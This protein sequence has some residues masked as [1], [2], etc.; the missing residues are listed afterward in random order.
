[1]TKDALREELSRSIPSTTPGFEKM[2]ED[3]W[4]KE[5]VYY[6][7]GWYGSVALFSLTSVSMGLVYY[8]YYSTILIRY[9]T[10][11]S[12]ATPLKFYV[13]LVLASM[14][15]SLIAAVIAL[16]SYRFYGLNKLVLPSNILGGLGRYSY[17]RSL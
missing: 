14:T 3:M 10:K 2:L 5:V 17:W 13:D 1:V 8:V 7:S 9:L 6:T 12:K 4:S 11:Y 16:Y 15:V